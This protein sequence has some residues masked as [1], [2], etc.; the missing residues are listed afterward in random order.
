M[1]A[2]QLRRAISARLLRV[3]SAG[4]SPRAMSAAGPARA[5]YAVR[6]L[7]AVGAGWLPFAGRAQ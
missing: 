2:G 4:P 6:L 7:R 1:S 3:T 5:T